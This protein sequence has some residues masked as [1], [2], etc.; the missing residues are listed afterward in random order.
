MK[1]AMKSISKELLCI[2]LAVTI[3]ISASG[4]S[5]G[6]GSGSHIFNAAVIGGVIGGIIGHQSDETEAGIAVGAT[7]FGV[8]AALAEMDKQHHTPSKEAHENMVK[9]DKA[10]SIRETYIIEIHN[11]NGSVTSVKIRRKGS[12][13]IGPNDERYDELPTEEQLKP[14]YGL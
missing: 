10:E 8:G 14:V 4:C 5:G 13:Y 12:V 1:R 6:K 9:N 11:S 3:I 7:L 2:S